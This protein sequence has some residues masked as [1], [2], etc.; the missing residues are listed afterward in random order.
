[1]QLTALTLLATFLA[2]VSADFLMSN[3]SICMG[4]LMIQQCYH[5]VKVLS[6][7][8]ETDNGKGYQCNHL[9]HAQD[10]NY[11][12]NGTAGPFGSPYV[13]SDGGICDS[14]R[15]DFVKDG[16]EYIVNDKSG[17]TVAHCEI[18]KGNYTQ[19]CNQWVGMLF[20]QAMY[21]CKGSVCPSP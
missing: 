1:M 14:G 20:F 4:T 11:I 19:H 21:R 10:N 18:E 16:E 15:L 12:H 3:T 6:Q 17:S 8:N 2:G 13:S 9:V 7:T 5:G